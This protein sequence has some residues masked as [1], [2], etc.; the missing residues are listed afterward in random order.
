[1]LKLIGMSTTHRTKQTSAQYKSVT[2]LPD[3][4]M[5]YTTAIG[6]F[7][8]LVTSQICQPSASPMQAFSTCGITLRQVRDAQ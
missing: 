1:M 3:E 8:S 5:I 2:G 7:V 6:A 4:A